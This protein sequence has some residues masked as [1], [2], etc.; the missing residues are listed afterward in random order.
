MKE[1]KKERKT[2]A[3]TDY[4]ILAVL[5]THLFQ[6]SAK[7]FEHRFDVTTFLHRDD[8]GMIF[9]VNPDQEILLLVVPGKR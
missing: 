1:R 7:S 2:C 6:T 3:T 9:L 8:P 5:Q 4:Q